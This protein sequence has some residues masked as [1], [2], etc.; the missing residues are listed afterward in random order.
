MAPK[1]AILSH[2]G[3]SGL[4]YR[5]IRSHSESKGFIWTHREA[6]WSS[7]KPKWA[8]ESLEEPK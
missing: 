7:R 3:A 8:T 2:L 1:R 5:A 6:L 4:P